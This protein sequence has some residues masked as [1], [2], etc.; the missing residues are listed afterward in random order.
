MSMENS[1]G[2]HSLVSVRAKI[3]ATDL[4]QAVSANGKS[5]ASTSNL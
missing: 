3:I 5:L 2:I 4:D 1:L